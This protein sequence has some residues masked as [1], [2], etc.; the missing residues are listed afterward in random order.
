MKLTILVALAALF[1]LFSGFQVPSLFFIGYLWASILYP[2]AFITLP[3]PI[4]L[5][6][7]LFCIGAFLISDKEKLGRYPAI[8]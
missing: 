5:L 4:S 7:G 3:I 6:F 1:M 8:C 2:S